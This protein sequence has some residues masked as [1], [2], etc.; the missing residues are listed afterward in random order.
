MNNELD[1]NKM[2][3]NDIYNLQVCI[4]LYLDTGKSHLLENRDATEDF[5][6]GTESDG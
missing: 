6:S 1:G 3:L 4:F 5:F 2:G